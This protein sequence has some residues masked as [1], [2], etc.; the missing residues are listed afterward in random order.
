MEEIGGGHGGKKPSQ[1]ALNWLLCK[2]A[3][4]IPGVKTPEQV[5]EAA[6]ALGW[7]MTDEEV[8]ALESAAAKI[9][10]SPGAPFENW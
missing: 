8:R 10:E 5:E 4:P 2:G 3:L 7:R 1:I 9:P 6:G